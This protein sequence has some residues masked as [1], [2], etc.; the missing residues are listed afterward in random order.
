MALLQ[1]IDLHV[2]YGAIKA[3]RGVSLEVE[4]GKII[5]LIGANGAGK[6]STL[7]AI[8]GIVPV[9][10]GKILFDGEDLTNAPTHTI[11]SR[12]ITQSLEGRQVFYRMS[13]RENLELG[14]YTRS[15]Q[16]IEEGVERGFTM[17]PV[18]KERQKQM[19]GTLSGG[20]QQMLA[21]AR[22]L[23]AKPRLLM[24][25]EPSLGL[26]PMIV[27]NVFEHVKE[28]N[29]SMNTTILLVEQ[30]ARMALS[31]SDYGFV[32]EMGRIQH[33]GPADELLHSEQIIDAYLG[34]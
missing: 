13:V 22:A 19:A 16:D 7:N 9:Q 21:I 23:M 12:G 28:I 31:I 33:A 11:V 10:S 34:A 3:V 27:Q 32:L 8:S 17:F 4:E 15:K 24:L 29:E 30:N 26:A 6:S 25:D 5:S 14:G 20:E 2:S 1:L 18:L